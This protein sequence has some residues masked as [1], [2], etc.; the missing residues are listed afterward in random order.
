MP[1]VID[2]PLE[3]RTAVSTPPLNPI[4]P[5]LARNRVVDTTASGALAASIVTLIATYIDPAMTVMAAAAWQVVITSLGTYI[6]KIARY[7]SKE[8]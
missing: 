3:A 7:R 1:I 6:L 2:R 5:N 4:P 8:E